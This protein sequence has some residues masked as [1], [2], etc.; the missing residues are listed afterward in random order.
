MQTP[1]TVEVGE[2]LTLPGDDEVG[3]AVVLASCGSSQDGFWLCVSHP[4]VHLRNQMQKDAHVFASDT[5]VSDHK[6]AWACFA[7]GIEKP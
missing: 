4:D 1:A 5:K 2:T 3:P 6:L 7:H